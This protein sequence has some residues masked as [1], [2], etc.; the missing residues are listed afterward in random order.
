MTVSGCTI[1][2]FTVVGTIISVTII[3]VGISAGT[4]SDS[5]NGG[6]GMTW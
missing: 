6:V 2:V 1:T 3:G 5:T 4:G